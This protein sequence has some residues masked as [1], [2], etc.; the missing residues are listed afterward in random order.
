MVLYVGSCMLG[1]RNSVGGEGKD[2][3]WAKEIPVTIADREA[4]YYSD[5]G[6]LTGTAGT[7]H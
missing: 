6:R 7:V 1:H 3:N 5:N 2:L 4:R